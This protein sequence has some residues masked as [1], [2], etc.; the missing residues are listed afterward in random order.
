MNPDPSGSVDCA[1]VPAP[2]L[3]KPCHKWQNAE[4]SNWPAEQFWLLT[5]VLIHTRKPE[6]W[7]RLWSMKIS[8]AYV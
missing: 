3:H 2:R 1:M 4:M 7:G 8:I 6:I 5:L